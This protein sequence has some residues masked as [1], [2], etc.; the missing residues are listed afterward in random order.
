[1]KGIAIPRFVILDKSVRQRVIPPYSYRPVLLELEEDALSARRMHGYGPIDYDLARY[2]LCDH[3][4]CFFR[5]DYR[6]RKYTEQTEDLLNEY[7]NKYCLTNIDSDGLIISMAYRSLVNQGWRGDIFLSCKEL[8]YVGVDSAIRYTYY[9]ATHG[10]MSRI[11]SVSEKYIWTFRHKVVALL[12][13]SIP[14][15]VSFSDRNKQ[16][17]HDYIDIENFINPYQDYVNNVY[18]RKEEKWHNIENLATLENKTLNKSAIENW[19]TN[20]GIPDFISWI[21]GN[22]SS[23]LLDTFTNVVNKAA[24]IEETV[25]IHSGAVKTCQF[26]SFIKS[27]DV[28]SAG[29]VELASGQNM[30]AYV[31]CRGFC[32]PQEICMIHADKEVES[33]T[34]II[35]DEEI[36]INK[37]VSSSLVSDELQTEITFT[38]PSKFTREITK[39]SYGDGYRYFDKTGN[40]VAQYYDNGENWG[41]QQQSL[42]IDRNRLF[43]GLNKKQYTPFWIYRVYRS[44]S[45][46]AYERF[47]DILH[48]TDNTF[49]VW[50]EDEN[51]KFKRLDDMAPPKAVQE[52]S[53]DRLSDFES[54]IAK[55]MKKNEEN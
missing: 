38:L 11:M 37:L 54:I 27:L 14:I 19:M 24:G 9:P 5:Q 18:R 4:D 20:E 3:L 42:F 1:M 46:K 15:P 55:Y 47:R 35:N 23:I 8:D 26:E 36:I 16:F 17:V 31:G 48:D 25:W 29:R 6:T 51:I 50:L 2:V 7:R 49:I 43:Q 33:T 34:A 30:S 12:A 39:I 22:D 10:S 21:I 13:N 52:D 32:T 44:P 45:N 40:D 53:K 41:T 28:Y